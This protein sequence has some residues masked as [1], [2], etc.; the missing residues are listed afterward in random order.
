MT[1]KNRKPRLKL[2]HIVFT[3]CL[4]LILAPA[5]YFG[6]MLASTYM[7]SHSP[8]L[9]NRYENDL[10]P[11]ITK[12]Q[13]KQV[14]EAV[15]K[16]DG[17]TGHS[18]HLATGTLRVYVDVAEDSTAEVVQDVTGRA[19][20]AVVA[21][22][23][24]NVYFSQGNDMKMYDL[25]IHTSNMKDGRDKDNFIYGIFTKTSAMSAPQYQLV[26]SPKNAEVAQSLRDAVTARKAAEAAAAAEAQAQKEQQPS[27]E[28][29]ENTESTQQTQQ[30]QQ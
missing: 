25:E 8:V 14:D 30:T 24:P 20:E 21:I 1:Q 15:G 17:V 27:T 26:S 10:N 5:I 19:Y 18:V 11:A 6:W 29:T 4:I 16:L 13:L 23:D 9:G 22:L 12:D 2:V 28:N 3:V 7:D